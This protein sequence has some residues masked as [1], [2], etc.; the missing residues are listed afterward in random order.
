GKFK[1]EDVLIPDVF[2]KS[3]TGLRNS[4]FYNDARTFV[5]S[6]HL[7]GKTL[8]P[9]NLIR[10]SGKLIIIPTGRLGIIPFETLLTKPTEENQSYATMPYLIRSHSIRY[11]F[12][13][14]LLLQKAK[15]T[16]EGASI[17]PSIMLCAP[18]TFPQKDHLSD[19]P[20][21]ES[22]VKEIS[23]LFQLKN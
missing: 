1:I 7:L 16:K 9:K 20:G 14:S 12:S 23:G 5:Q 19:L 13:A 22:E 18:I 8:L 2:E 3:I 10:K 11:E 15:N 17:T 6:S 21:T 4:L